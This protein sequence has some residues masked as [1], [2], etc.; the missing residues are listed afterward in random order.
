MYGDGGPP[1]H[2]GNAPIEVCALR[3]LASALS[4]SASATRGSSTLRNPEPAPALSPPRESSSQGVSSSAIFR[5]GSAAAQVSSGV[6][7]FDIS[8]AIVATA[9]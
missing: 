7:R 3:S 5:L 4:R 2:H 1:G 9:G 6:S 8:R